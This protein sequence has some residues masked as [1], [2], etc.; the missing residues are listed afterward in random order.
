MTAVRWHDLDSNTYERMIAVLLNTIHPTSERIDGAGGDDGRDVQLRNGHRVDFFELK[1]QTGR[2]GA[3]Q[4]AQIQQSLTRA[5]THKPDSWTLVIPIDPT[6]KELKWFDKLKA[7]Y[8]FPLQWWGQTWLDRQMAERPHIPRY[9]IEGAADEVI[10]IFLRLRDDETGLARGLE[11]VV[12]RVEGWVRRLNDID[13]FWAFMISRSPE[14]I[15]TV[16]PTPK[17]RGAEKDRPILI[18]FESR[19][20]TTEEGQRALDQLQTAI[21]FG[22]PAIVPKEYV[23]ALTIDAPAGLGGTL[24]SDIAIASAE[25]T[26]ASGALTLLA[27]LED[28]SVLGSLPLRITE[29]TQGVAGIELTACDLSKGLRMRMRLRGDSIELA[30]DFRFR[31]PAGALPVEVAPT[32]R[33]ITHVHPPNRIGFRFDG[34]VKDAALS[35]QLEVSPMSSLWADVLEA[36]ARIQTSS[37]VYFPVPDELTEKDALKVFEVD[38]LLRG[39]PIAMT[40]G[41]MVTTLVVGEPMVLARA[42]QTMQ[43]GT[44]RIVSDREEDLL[45]H[46]IPIPQ[47]AIDLAS[48]RVANLPEL[49]ALLPYQP[50]MK[51]TLDLEPSGTNDGKLQRILST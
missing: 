14:G 7:E 6:P 46:K 9:F 24:Q 25:E 37:H 51:L 22:R 44:L 49:E 5:A 8:P 19:F 30:S 26:A 42:L 39:E 18:H 48:A 33:F 27:Y 21:D 11:D 35:Q 50:G 34:S 23:T 3:A 36:L 13:P 15:Y 17:Y 31:V 10:D 29:R 47:V 2:V 43:S 45:G 41:R 40:W 28:G 38:Q 20:P 4:R 1:S 12:S 32:V 16:T